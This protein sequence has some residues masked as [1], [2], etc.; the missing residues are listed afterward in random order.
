MKFPARFFPIIVLGSLSTLLGGCE[1]SLNSLAPVSGKIASGIIITVAGSGATGGDAGNGAAATM[2][3][4]S[5]PEGVALDSQGNLYIA[6]PSEIRKVNT[7]GVISAFAG[8]GAG[9]ESG[10]GGTAIQAQL[11]IAYHMALDAGGNLYFSEIDGQRIRQVNT[12]SIISTFAG[13]GTQWYSG[14][15]GPAT[16]AEFDYPR[17]L[18]VD[19]A[20]NVYVADSTFGRIR[21]IDTAGTI[22]TVAGNGSNSYSGDGGPATLASFNC[23]DVAVDA[24][25]N[26]Y[27]ADYWNQRVRKVT[28]DGNITTV[29]GDGTQGFSG[30]GEAATSAELNLPTAITVDD[31]GNI[32][33]A[34]SGNN[35]IREVNTNGVITTVAGNGTAGYGGDGGSAVLAQLDSPEDVAVDGQ[36]H[37]FIADTMNYRV[38]EVIP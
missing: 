18:A 4:L 37:L 20:G 30:D 5:D 22:T 15:G 19:G 23:W 7:S 29:A 12:A 21:K 13:N 32:Y 31:S 11:N 26:L 9:G 33:I 28:S 3:V 24:S 25:G 8:N 27:I 1:K 16:Q 14:D 6:D 36:G 34:D 2:A 17:G 10:D 38:R 35:R